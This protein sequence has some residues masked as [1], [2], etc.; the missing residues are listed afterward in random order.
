MYEL[1]EDQLMTQRLASDFA[2]KEASIG[3]AERYEN[4]EFP[5]ELV[6]R[7][8]ELGLMGITI[9]EKYGGSGGDVISFCLA[10]YEITKVDPSLALTCW[11]HV[12]LGCWPIYTLGTEA[13]KQKWLVPL[14]KG[15]KLAGM[16]T[17]EP[18][19]GSDIQGVRTVARVE[20]NEWVINGSKTFIT[21]SGTSITLGV[22]TFCT[23]GFT[24]KG[25][26]QFSLIFVPTHVPG[27]VIMP[28]L[29]KVGLRAS[30]THEL[31][32]DNCRVPKENLLGE[33]GRAWYH[34]MDIL[35]K[36]RILAAV[37]C[38]GMASASFELALDYAKER[39]AF[40]KRIGDFQYSAFQLAEMHMRIQMVWNFII[41]AA[42]LADHGKEF[43]EE[44]TISRYAAGDVLLFCSQNAAQLF[45]GLGFMIE[46]PISR[47][48]RD[49]RA[50]QIGEGTSEVMKMV[51]ARMLG[52]SPR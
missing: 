49:A 20:G 32:F 22:N 25:K 41:K 29:K 24:E 10:I 51:I 18:D 34:L 37:F 15:E 3:V 27:L 19:A 33:E 4:M 21:N 52:L 5:Y 50:A 2:K 40:G 9:P 13:Q 1:T 46:S 26:K 23:T 31:T 12:C 7:L 43:V 17:T 42:W 36:S 14:A 6:K 28:E 45:G 35:D 16:A 44:A 11:A 48:N 30:D 8:G 39:K 38:L 47:F